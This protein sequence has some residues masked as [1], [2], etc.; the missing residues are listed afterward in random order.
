MKKEPG[1]RLFFLAFQS[2]NFMPTS[3]AVWMRGWS[4]GRNL[5]RLAASAR[6]TVT[7]CPS[8]MPTMEAYCFSMMSRAAAVPNCVASTRS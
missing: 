4:V 5:V 8:R 3:R 6:G 1:N 2:P 7:M